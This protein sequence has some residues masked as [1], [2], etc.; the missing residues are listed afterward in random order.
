MRASHVDVVE[1]EERVARLEGYLVELIQRL[2]RQAGHGF[3]DDDRDL[4]SWVHD[5]FVATSTSIRNAGGPWG[6]EAVRSRAR[7]AREA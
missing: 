7:E 2:A 5:G 6:P 3:D 1:L 4:P